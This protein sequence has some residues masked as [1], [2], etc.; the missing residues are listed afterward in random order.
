MKLYHGGVPGLVPGQ[1]LQPPARTG[2]PSCSDYDSKHSRSDRVYV[3]TDPEEAAVYAALAPWGGRGDVYEVEPGGELE[4]EAP[5][6]AGAGSYAAPTATV[7]AVVRRAISP[8]EAIAWM[9]AFLV[10]AGSSNDAVY[11]RTHSSCANRRRRRSRD[12]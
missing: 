12:A 10:N 5:G 8:D 6:E 9:T 7:V 11:G 1:I 2:T 3:T 4:P